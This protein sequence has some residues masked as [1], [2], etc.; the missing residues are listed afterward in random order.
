[1]TMVQFMLVTEVPHAIKVFKPNG[2][3]T[4]IGSS[5]IAGQPRLSFPWGIALVGDTIYAVSNQCTI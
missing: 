1:M 2:E 4:K 5:D 3:E